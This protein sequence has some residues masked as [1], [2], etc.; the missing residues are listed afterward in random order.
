M[1]FRSFF[2]APER[3]IAMAAIIIWIASIAQAVAI[4]QV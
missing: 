2:K 4:S 1:E 3:M